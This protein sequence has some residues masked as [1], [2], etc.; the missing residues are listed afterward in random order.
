MVLKRVKLLLEAVTGL[1]ERLVALT[2]SFQ[3][4]GELLQLLIVA[5]IFALA[6]LN[7]VVELIGA[8]TLRLFLADELA[9]GLE[10]EVVT[11]V[12][13]LAVLLQGLRLSLVATELGPGDFK[14]G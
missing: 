9:L 1:E 8:G 4:S 14:L 13:I 2:Y 10:K 12:R 3:L 5:K 11:T 6:V 7:S